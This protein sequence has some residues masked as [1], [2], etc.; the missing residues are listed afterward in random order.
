MAFW[1]SWL[2]CLYKLVKRCL[3]VCVCLDVN[4][5]GTNRNRCTQ[6]LVISHAQTYKRTP[7]AHQK[8]GQS[9][10][11][12]ESKSPAWKVGTNNVRENVCNNSKKTLKV[13]FLDFQKTLNNVRV[14][15]HGC[16]MFI[17]PLHCCQNLTSSP[18]DVQQ[19]LRM[20]HTRGSVNWITVIT[21]R[22]MWTHFDG[23]RTKL[24]LKIFTTFWYVISKKLK[25]RVFWNTYV[26]SNSGRK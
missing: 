12:Y 22:S 26:F 14:I 21:E 15:F 17:V 24:L 7:I 23:L 25:S 5:G 16:L 10:L 4:Q 6:R 9:G 1:L 8:L 20:D 19:W 3:S 18:L 2:G 11:L 13:V